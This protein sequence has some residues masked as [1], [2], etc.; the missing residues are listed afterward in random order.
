MYYRKIN[1]FLD[2]DKLVGISLA[3]LAR[4]REDELIY[5]GLMFILPSVTLLSA[6][7]DKK[8][9]CARV[10]QEYFLWHKNLRARM[11]NRGL[12]LMKKQMNGHQIRVLFSGIWVIDGKI[13]LQ[14][15]IEMIKR[16]NP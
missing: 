15:E 13:Y 12:R 16:I 6:H 11:G 1:S 2:I 14:P 3:E 5:Y 7:G 8:F 4:V 10:S 9:F